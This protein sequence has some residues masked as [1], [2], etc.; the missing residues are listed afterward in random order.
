MGGRGGQVKAAASNV[1]VPCPVT[2]PHG[3]RAQGAGSLQPPLPLLPKQ[4]APAHILLLAGS[5]CGGAAAR[6]PLCDVLSDL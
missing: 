2:V 3:D 1:L 4:E 5:K 6:P